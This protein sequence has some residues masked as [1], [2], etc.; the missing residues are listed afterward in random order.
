MGEGE[1]K[2]VGASSVLGSRV[3]VVGL[4]L[5]VEEISEEGGAVALVWQAQRRAFEAQILDMEAPIRGFVQSPAL[6]L[7]RVR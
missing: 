1:G 4:T 6:F 3:A 5:A 7:A 2:S